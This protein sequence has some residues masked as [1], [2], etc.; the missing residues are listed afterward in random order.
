MNSITLAFVPV[1]G[2]GLYDTLYVSINE[3]VYTIRYWGLYST[4]Y[5]ISHLLTFKRD[6]PHVITHHTDYSMLATPYIGYILDHPTAY[7]DP[8]TLVQ[9]FITALPD[10]TETVDSVTYRRS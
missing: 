5:A 2:A 8:E 9:E 3:E 10:G 6:T 1:Q 4:Q 7:I